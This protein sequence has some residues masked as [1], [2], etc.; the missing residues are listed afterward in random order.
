MKIGN[1]TFIGS[2]NMAKAL[3][4]GLVN[5]GCS[6]HSIIA[7]TPSVDKCKI[8]ESQLGV[9]VMTDNR[10]A[11]EQADAVILAVKPDVVLTVCK[12]LK[13]SFVAKKPIIISV[14]AGLTTSLLA[15]WLDR[16][17]SIVRAMP[18]I[19]VSVLAGSTGLYSNENVSEDQRDHVEALFRA[20]GVTVWVEQE[21]DMDLITAFSGSGP[22]YYFLIL[23][24]M[25]EA[26]C[27]MGLKSSVAKLFSLQTALGAV[28]M[29]MESQYEVNELLRS[30][31]SPKGATE[32]ALKVLEAREIR[33]IIEQALLAAVARG[34]TIAADLL[35]LR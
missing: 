12:E 25:Q 3:I 7:T 18:N 1:I 23:E 31:R 10:L 28:K 34:R 2:G 14:A 19:P 6:P 32:A 24:A 5:M 20:V 29:A 21:R 30:V 27:K 16:S 9:R 13:R 8:L 17:L 15:S 26:A 33:Q 35:K 22:A 4:V 11:I